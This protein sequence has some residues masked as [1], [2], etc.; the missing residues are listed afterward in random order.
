M[1]PIDNPWHSRPIDVH[2]WSDHPEVGKIV[3]KLWGEFFSVFVVS[4]NGISCCSKSSREVRLHSFKS[5]LP[6]VEVFWGFQPKRPAPERS[7]LSERT[8]RGTMPLDDVL[9]ERPANLRCACA[10]HRH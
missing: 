3:D 2:R 10:T 8:S 1:A 5:G 9:L 7:V 4:S 6:M